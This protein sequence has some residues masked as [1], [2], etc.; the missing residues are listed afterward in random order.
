[1]NGD[2]SPPPLRLPLPPVTLVLGG[3]RSGKSAFGQKL[4]LGAGG[5]PVLI[6]TARVSAD[7]DE[8][9]ARIERHKS[10]RGTEWRTIEEEIELVAALTRTD[11]GD[12]AI[13]VDCLTLWLANLMEDGRDPAAELD[14]LAG[15]L[16][17]L[18]SP[19]VLVSNEVGAGIVPAN[20]LARARPVNHD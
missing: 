3:A 19:V 18:A 7:D 5:A 10:E 20:A 17:G 14:R 9:A 8:M 12:R 4:V 16:A 2:I 11:A 1:M 15:C 13:L 6:A